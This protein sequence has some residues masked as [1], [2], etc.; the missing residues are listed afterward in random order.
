[1]ISAILAVIAAA[2]AV[3][4]HESLAE[5]PLAGK[6]GNMGHS[7]A[8][9]LLFAGIY[10]IFRIIFDSLVPGN[11]QVPPGLDKAGGAAMG[12]VAGVFAGGVVAV[13]AQAM[14]FWPSIA[15]Y[16]RY[17]VG[18]TEAAVF[19]SG[20]KREDRQV[21]DLMKE[22]SFAEARNTGT[23]QALLVPVDDILVGTVARLSDGSLAGRQSLARVHPDWLTELFGQRLGIQSA[24]GR[25]A[26]NRGNRQDV[27]VE[28]V[29]D[30][31]NPF[32]DEGKKRVAVLEGEF[33]EIRREQG[34]VDEAKFKSTQHKFYV[35]RTFFDRTAADAGVGSGGS[36]I[37]LSPGAVRLVTKGVPPDGGG[38]LEW[39]NYYPIGTLDDAR[40]LFLSRPDDFLFLNPG[41]KPEGQNKGVD[42]VFYVNPQG[43]VAGEPAKITDGTFL[44]V[45]R[46][47]RV[48]L[49]GME[50]KTKLLPNDAVGVL[51]KKLVLEQATTQPAPPKVR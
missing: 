9:L 31:V 38:E 46:S 30:F 40:Y 43:F 51:R 50:V 11:V 4:Y 21:F 27:T 12:L 3:S 7:V 34:R 1:V 22:T 48:D 29:Y 44:E 36:I 45:K 26:I 6:M 24:A 15:G 16:A 33:A 10:L 14:P 35:V 39:V 18:N 8:L 25:V 32:S 47:A 28:G 42:F 19:A 5:G 20:G 49:G 23:V 37:R 13:A 2:L 17:P 41:G